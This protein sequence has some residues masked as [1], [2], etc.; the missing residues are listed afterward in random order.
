V[1]G[2]GRIRRPLEALPQRAGHDG[3]VRLRDDEL[4]AERRIGRRDLTQWRSAGGRSLVRLV[5]TTFRQVAARNVLLAT[6]LVG[7]LLS[8][9]LTALSAK[10]Y[11]AVAERDGVAVLDQPVLDRAIAW[12]TPLLNEGVTGFTNLGGAVGM[13]VL[14]GLAV[15]VMLLAWRSWTP[16]VLM[17]IA[18][19][20][21]LAMTAVGKGLIGRVRPPLSQAVP[22]YEQSPSFPSGHTLNSTVV[23]GLVVYL[24]LVRL[25][26]TLTRVTVTAAGTAFV[27]AMGL[28]RVFL[29][30]HWLTDVMVGWTLGLAWL[31]AVVTAHRIFLTVRRER[32]GGPQPP[33]PPHPAGVR[34]R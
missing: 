9:G 34:S 11:E 18:S 33:Q 26:S 12:R 19:A 4:S 10:V 22:P 6:A 13:P 25:R 15:G 17:L 8:V 14:T 23:V 32:A 27:V 7:G 29:G 3:A 24:L 30:H 28:S 16:L 5:L 20:G 2:G 21:S 1:R 31:G